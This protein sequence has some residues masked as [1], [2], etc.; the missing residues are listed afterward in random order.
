VGGAAFPFLDLLEYLAKQV[1]H[2]SAFQVHIKF[3]SDYVFLILVEPFEIYSHINGSLLHLFHGELSQDREGKSEFVQV[4][5]HLLRESF[6]DS[7]IESGVWRK[8]RDR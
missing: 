6:L 4:P 8:T 1:F 2:F 7:Q 3:N 5:L